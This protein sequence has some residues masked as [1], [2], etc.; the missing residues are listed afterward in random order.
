[1]TSMEK[2]LDITTN[3]IAAKAATQTPGPC[4]G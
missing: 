4:T 1:M 3:V 2:A